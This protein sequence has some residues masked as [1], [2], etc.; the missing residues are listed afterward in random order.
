[1]EIPMV[2]TNV[3]TE[4][5]RS[6]IITKIFTPRVDFR[7]TLR[8]PT[9][10]PAS[11]CEA[12]ECITEQST[13]SKYVETMPTLL[14]TTQSST[15]TPT[16]Q[17][18]TLESTEPPYHQDL[19]TDSTVST[20]ELIETPTMKGKITLHYILHN[21]SYNIKEKITISIVLII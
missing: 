18:S 2:D 7:K 20:T 16:M 19:I 6:K 5:N 1:M 21:S 13:T 14:S 15:T 10:T 4:L 17:I 3:I 12:A 11:A 8:I 9:A